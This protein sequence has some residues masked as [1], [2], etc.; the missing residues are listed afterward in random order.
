MTLSLLQP[1]VAGGEIILYSPC[2]FNYHDLEPALSLRGFHS[3]HFKA[4]IPRPRCR[5]SPNR[6][7]SPFLKMVYLRR[8][9][10]GIAGESSAFNCYDDQESRGRKPRWR[11]ILSTSRLCSH[12]NPKKNKLNGC[13]RRR[14]KGGGTNIHHVDRDIYSA[15]TWETTHIE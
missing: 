5:S 10:G 12:D 2:L 4:A 8:N 7:L 1:L 6:G 11:Y 15:E 9:C 3:H 14:P 13:R